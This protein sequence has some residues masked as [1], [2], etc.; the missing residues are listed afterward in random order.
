MSTDLNSSFDI[1]IISRSQYIAFIIDYNDLI[2]DISN[3]NVNNESFSFDFF[4]QSLYKNT[5]Y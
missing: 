4:E 1:N 2:S 5:R 3:F